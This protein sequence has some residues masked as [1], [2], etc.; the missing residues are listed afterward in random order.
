M[1]PQGGYVPNN[2][3]ETG[4]SMA[5]EFHTLKMQSQGIN[6]IHSAISEFIDNS[7]DAKA[8]NVYIKSVDNKK[9]KFDLFILDN[10]NGM[11]YEKLM[12]IG[13]V[14]ASRK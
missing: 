14:G 9:G 10:G 12:T 3:K 4:V 8:D 1:T 11:T 7:M 6:S 2:L 5:P 13:R